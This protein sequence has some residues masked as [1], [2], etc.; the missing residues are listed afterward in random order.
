MLVDAPRG[1]ET[2]TRQ[3]NLRNRET[4]NYILD[5][6]QALVYSHDSS[7]MPEP[8]SPEIRAEI[9]ER[10]LR[11]YLLM[12]MMATGRIIGAFEFETH[13]KDLAVGADT[14]EIG[15]IIA[16][17]TAIAIQNANQLEEITT[18]TR[19]L[20]MLLEAAQTTSLMMDIDEVFS[21]VVDLMLNTLDMEDCAVMIWDDVENVLEVQ[22]DVNRAGDPDRVSPEGTRFDLTDYPARRE[23]LRHKD[24]VILHAGEDNEDNAEQKELKGQESAL[25]MLVPLVVRD[26]SIGL[27]Q[28]DSTDPH[29]TITEQER[30]LARALGAQVAVAIENARLSSETAA[31]INELFVI[32]DLSR[33]ISASLDVESVL[34]VVKEQVPNV[35]GASEMYIAFYDSETEE[36]TFPVAVADGGTWTLRRGSLAPTK[37]RS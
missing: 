28:V 18:R 9:E 34:E 30:R 10:G 8:L 19:E 7:K 13:T 14:L 16:S 29:R 20:E 24:V 1:A 31:Q 32:N 4:Y 26:Q 37:F 11:E 36:I 21:T 27:I 22:I 25:R 3:F 5:R 33:A 15:Q 23:A 2:P 35:T 17:Q 6:M 12:P